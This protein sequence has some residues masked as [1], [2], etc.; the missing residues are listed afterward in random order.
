[1]PQRTI[2]FISNDTSANTGNQ[3]VSALGN[4]MKINLSNPIYLE[5][6]NEKGETNH[7][8]MELLQASIAYVFPNIFTGVNDTLEV[9]L[10]VNSVNNT[11]VITFEQGIYSLTSIN[12][13]IQRVIKSLGTTPGAGYDFQ[14][15]YDPST[16]RTYI[17]LND[18]NV[19]IFRANSNLL[20]TFG[21]NQTDPDI[22]SSIVGFQQTPNTTT[23]LANT[24]YLYITCDKINSTIN[25]V[26]NN[27]L[28]QIDISDFNPGVSSY[29]TNKNYNSIRCPIN[30]NI[31]TNLE[32]AVVNERL[33]DLD[34]T[35]NNP[36]GIPQG[37]SLTVQISND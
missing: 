26:S 6:K 24:K 33:E 25:D 31:I 16:N 15:I 19:V 28:K 30:S 5:Q 1:M 11:Y 9:Q 23:S 29:I 7:W 12:Q 35:F 13:E 8:H 17:E 36:G 37:I 2:L 22:T 21:F 34:F 10:N 20:P 3:Q 4:R 32:F 14:L 27:I 18:P